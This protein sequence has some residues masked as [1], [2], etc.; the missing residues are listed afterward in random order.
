MDGNISII[1]PLLSGRK[2]NRFVS[3][4]EWDSLMCVLF[5]GMSRPERIRYHMCTD[6]VRLILSAEEL[7]VDCCIFFY[8]E[9]R[10]SG[11][12]NGVNGGGP[13]PVSTGVNEC[14]RDKLNLTYFWLI[15][16][17][18]IVLKGATANIS[19]DMIKGRASR[20]IFGFLRR[21]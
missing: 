9:F 12:P 2:L 19:L 7:N 13:R 10:R 6:T 5:C 17:G 20:L 3:S 1:F 21:I 11:E 14:C 16:S 15:I 18:L 8:V 4:L